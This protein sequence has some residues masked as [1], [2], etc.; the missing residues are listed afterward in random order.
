[1]IND[2][3]WIIMD[4]SATTSR[5]SGEWTC[6]VSNE[7]GEAKS[8]AYL[9]VSSKESIIFDSMQP[10]SLERIMEMEAEKPVPD[11]TPPKVSFR[12]QLIINKS[13]IKKVINSRK[14]GNF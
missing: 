10:Q 6:V 4:I 13:F 14:N 1:M 3:G 11:E 5:D 9:N 7:A 8:S 12:D 2:F